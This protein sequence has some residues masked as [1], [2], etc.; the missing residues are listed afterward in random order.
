[1]RATLP[2]FLLAST[3]SGAAMAQATPDTGAPEA[4]SES[5]WWVEPR[6]RLQLDV[7][8]VDLPA[9]MPGGGSD[10]ELRR[11]YLGI[12][13]G[14]PGGF[15]YRIEADF[16]GGA[17]E[18]TDAYL[19]YE[20]ADG[21]ELT[22]GHQ[23]TFQGMDDMTSDLF[24]S[25]LERAA[26]TSA[27]GFERRVGLSG[28]Y[29]AGNVTVQ[30]G[31]FLDDAVAIDDPGNDSFSFDG[32]VVFSPKVGGGRLHVGGSAHVRELNDPAATVR[33]RARPFV[34]ATDLRL[35]DTGDF[36]ATG[37]RAFG[38]ELAYTAG[39]FHAIAE[40]HRLTARRPGLPDANFH[41]GYLEF[42]MVVTPGDAPSYKEG[43]FDRL[44]PS[45]PISA[46]GI[47]AIQ[48]NARYDALDLDH[49]AI[50]GGGQ[51]V[52]GL[53]AVWVPVSSLRFVF[54]YGRVWIDDSGAE[55]SY[56]VDTFGMRAQIDF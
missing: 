20:A 36:A 6:G 24:T 56:G 53:S 5:D 13:G 1:M 35:V 16:A 45:R 48:L 27:F 55:R 41:G 28:V 40:G 12:D 37:E 14:M 2:L 29:S 23:K 7:A 52:L 47:G 17:V 46:G 3:A 39:P 21:L 9:A 42:G 11:F 43:N 54:N 51:Q 49:G 34:H 10:G 4:K 26:F 19:T 33:Y 8:R 30:F 18:L 31:A 22:L 38:A 50:R 25:M 32:R 44:S 15:G